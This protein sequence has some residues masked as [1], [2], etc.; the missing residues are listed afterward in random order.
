MIIQSK[1]VWIASQ[2]VPAQLEVYNG[3]ILV[4]YPYQTKKADIDVENDRIIPGFIDVH[5]HGAYG[6]DTNDAYPEGLIK[7]L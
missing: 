7:V 2:F 6:F 3:K 4:V 1:R 5:V